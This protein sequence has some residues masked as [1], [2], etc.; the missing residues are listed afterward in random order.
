LVVPEHLGALDHTV[1]DRMQYVAGSVDA[2]RDE[3][4]RFMEE[5]IVVRQAQGHYVEAAA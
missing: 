1:L 3:F 2:F 4:Q 5:V